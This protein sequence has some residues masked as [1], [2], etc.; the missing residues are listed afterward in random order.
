[1]TR[2]NDH[3]TD[4]RDGLMLHS[5]FMVNDRIK[6]LQATA[7][8]IR[9]E[10]A[11]TT[12]GGTGVVQGLRLRLGATL[13]A[14]GSALVSSASPVAPGRAGRQATRGRARSRTAGPVATR[15]VADRLLRRRLATPKT[16]ALKGAGL[17]VLLDVGEPDRASA[18]GSPG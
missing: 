4:E 8:E 15:R 9:H 12:A 1:M 13:L 16:R 2:C 7:A 18:P 14:I 11:M 5:S 17:P 6:D 10:R 3:Q